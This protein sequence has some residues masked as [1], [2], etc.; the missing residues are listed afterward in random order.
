MNM[1][2]AAGGAILLNTLLYASYYAIS[3]EVLGRVD[4]IV[5]S[6]CEM[7]TL[8][9]PALFILLISRRHL[10]R[11]A[12]KSGFLLGSCLCLGLLMLATALRHNSATA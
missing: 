7:M 6:F 4:P 1:K 9:P 3:K 5:F 11:Q 2:Y 10:T 12:I 8:A